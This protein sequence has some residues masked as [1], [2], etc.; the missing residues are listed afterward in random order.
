MPV[1]LAYL[2]RCAAETRYAAATLEK[3]VYLGEL[4]GAI[5]RHPLLGAALAL[6]G[7]TA[8]NLCFGDAPARLSVDLDYNY[9]ASVDREVML[10][11]RP[12]IESVIET[13]AQRLG[14]RVQRSADAFAGRKLYACYRSVLGP[15][16]RVEVDL[17]YL[18]RVPLAGVEER[19]MWQPGELDRPRVRTVSL[20]ELCVGKLLA[21]LDRSAPRD[22][23]DLGQFPRIA[24]DTIQSVAFRGLFI[25]FSATLPHPLTAYSREHI[26]GRLSDQVVREQLSPMLAGDHPPDRA[27]LLEGAWRVVE[28]FVH[29]CADETAYVEE[30]GRG[31]VRPEL[32]FPED[33]ALCE[34]IVNHP[35]IR[36]KAANVLQ[37]LKKRNG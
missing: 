30:I 9:V 11:E 18:W 10:Q 19:E 27:A 17:N 6:K 22:A 20:T 12:E 23:W 36:W 3:V 16:A 4:A 14:F 2:N 24:E 5:A 34:R 29:L 35:A 7:G 21:F 1:S 8:F 32:L 15:E 25:A 33:S 31:G 37:E 28:P 13:L 26:E